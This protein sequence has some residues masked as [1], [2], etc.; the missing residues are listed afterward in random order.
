VV[1]HAVG[2]N[3]IKRAVSEGQVFG[4]SLGKA[5]FQSSQL[6]APLRD[7]HRR[8]SEINRGIVSSGA[9]ETFG[10]AATSAADFEH[11]QASGAFKPHCRM[12]A[13]MHFVPVLVQTPVESKS[14]T[15]LVR[16][17]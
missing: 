11:P 4:V 17:P 15:R 8:I 9:R 16:K 10:F 5:S 3:E 13:R 6:K 1:K 14:P 2:I 7:T 12:Q